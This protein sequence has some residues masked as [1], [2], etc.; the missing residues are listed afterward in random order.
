MGA[1]S[2]RLWQ[3]GRVQQLALDGPAV[4]APEALR[5]VHVVTAV[6]AT[7]RL[8]VTVGAGWGDEPA[9]RVAD[10]V[11]GAGFVVVDGGRVRAGRW[12]GVVE[13]QRTLPDTV[14]PGLRLLMVGLNPSV[15]AADA[16]F[17]FASP[18]NRYWRAALAASVVSVTHDPPR[19]LAVDRVGMTDLVKRATPKSAE[20]TVA[21]YRAGAARVGRLAAWLQPGALC[22]VGL[23]GWRAA[24]ERKALPGW[25]TTSLGGRPTYVMPSTSGLNASVRVDDL[26]AHLRRAIAGPDV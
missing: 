5:A 1:V 13:R 8:R 18:S 4:E 3:P 12:T 17:G 10:V 2:H 24:V 14:G 23:E 11:L 25:Q 6:G 16:G 9:V 19:A 21:E 22:L 26:V 15:I 20:V 7:V